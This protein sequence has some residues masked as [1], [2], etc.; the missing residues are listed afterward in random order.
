MVVYENDSLGRPE[1][2][3]D[4][5]ILNCS[6]MCSSEKNKAINDEVLCIEGQ[7][8]ILCLNISHNSEKGLCL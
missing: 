4:V 1:K 6:N 8:G 3:K 5:N 7:T 2:L